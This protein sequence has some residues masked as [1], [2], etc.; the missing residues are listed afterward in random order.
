M[1]E[2]RQWKDAV[3]RGDW[4]TGRAIVARY[5]TESDLRY[6]QAVEQ[7]GL[8]EAALTLLDDLARRLRRLERRTAASRRN[9]T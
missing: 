7:A 1:D 4:E 6:W 2:A 5:G 8:R 9:V 3:N